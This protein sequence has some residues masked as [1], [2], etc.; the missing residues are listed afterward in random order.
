MLNVFG[1]V[2]YKPI[3]KYGVIM[4]NYFISKNGDVVSTRCKKTARAIRTSIK[5]NPRSKTL[6]YRHFAMTI[7]QSY[8]EE[9][10][11]DYYQRSVVSEGIRPLK[12]NKGELITSVLIPLRVH[13]AV[14]WSWKPIDDYPPVPK[15]EWDKT[16]E[17]VKQLLRESICVDHIDGN[18]LNNHVDNLR[19]TS[20]KGNNVWRKMDEYESDKYI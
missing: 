2:E 8:V 17:S 4:P 3:R 14:M 15:E 12:R 1:E 20:Q 7:D 5:K 9:Q 13:Q 16:P 18:S 6:R 11:G 10:L 19:Y